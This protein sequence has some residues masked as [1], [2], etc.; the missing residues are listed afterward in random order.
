MIKMAYIFDHYVRFVPPIATRKILLS[1]QNADDKKSD[2]TKKNG[3][4]PI[5]LSEGLSKRAKRIYGRIC[6]HSKI[7]EN[8]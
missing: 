6:R 3:R 2:F 5:K 4:L 8:M 7:W 1:R